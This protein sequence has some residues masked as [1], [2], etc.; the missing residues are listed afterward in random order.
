MR[1]KRGFRGYIHLKTIPEAS[2][3]LIEQAGLW[4]DRLSI[5]LE[6]PTDEGLKAFRAGEESGGS[7]KRRHAARS[8]ERIS[9]GEGGEAFTSRPPGNRRSSSSGRTGPTID[10]ILRTSDEALSGASDLKRR[11]YYSA[12][13]PIP[14]SAAILAGEVAASAA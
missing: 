9:G 4:A 14:D 10:A 3:W 1:Q 7:I 11:V 12:F 13:S 5:N 2:P 6:L 8:R